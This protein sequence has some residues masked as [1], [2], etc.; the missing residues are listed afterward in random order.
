MVIKSLRCFSLG[1]FLVVGVLLSLGVVSADFED[2]WA[3]SGTTQGE[4][5]AV[6]GCN[7]ETQEEDPWCD[8][9]PGCCMETGC[10][11][12]DGNESACTDFNLNGD[13]S[14]QFWVNMNA[15]GDTF[16]SL[17]SKRIRDSSIPETEERTP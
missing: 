9:S 3:K 13:F 15:I 2:C 17:I 12:Y 10:W 6:S 8:M 7:W 1:V 16:Y 4:C 5:E 11:N 14:V